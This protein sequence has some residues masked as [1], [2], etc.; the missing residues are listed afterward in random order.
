MKEKFMK[1][2]IQQA[3]LAK[4]EGEVPVG[5]VVVKDGKVVARG[6]NNREKTLQADGHAEMQA[7]KEAC[8]VLNSPFLND[9]DIYVTLEPCPM[10]AGAI[11]QARMRKVIF[12]AYEDKSGAVGS[13]FN[14]FY[15]FVMPHKVLFEGGVMEDECQRLMTDFFK[16]KR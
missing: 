1:Q 9:C 16:E 6:R 10:C 3:E 2:A 13:V 14:L 11:L 8:K 4:A 5:A 7:I 15:D 12:G